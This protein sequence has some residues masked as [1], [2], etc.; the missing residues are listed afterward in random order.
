M[1]APS[2]H[3]GPAFPVAFRWNAKQ[4]ILEDGISVRDYFAGQ[5]LAGMCA[6]GVPASA[7]DQ[8]KWA[9][10]CAEAMLAARKEGDK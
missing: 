10:E 1:S 5:A 2:K 3:G 8:A 7:S 4:V 9:Y 6:N